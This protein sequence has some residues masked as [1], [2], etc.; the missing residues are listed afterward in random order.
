L[1]TTQL[2]KI[3]N[4]RT[5]SASSSRWYKWCQISEETELD[6]TPA[7]FAAEWDLLSWIEWYIA[8]PLAQFKLREYGGEL[9]SPL[10]IALARGHETLV[11]RLLPYIN[12]DIS[13]SN[14]WTI[15]K[16]LTPFDGGEEMVSQMRE[17]PSAVPQATIKRLL[18]GFD[19]SQGRWYV[20]LI[21]CGD[22]LGLR[23][24]LQRTDSA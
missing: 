8:H 19:S 3:E 5:L 16:Y 23:E 15:E 6:T 17:N 21:R 14:G 12:L 11:T 1:H 13:D 10:L 7:Y 20:E 24:R 22:M 9:R 4:E 18:R 2:Q